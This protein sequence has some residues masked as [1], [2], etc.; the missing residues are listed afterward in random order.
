MEVGTTEN[1]SAVI[2]EYMEVGTTENSIQKTW[3]LE[4]RIQ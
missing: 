4:L 2:Q 1:S 3:R